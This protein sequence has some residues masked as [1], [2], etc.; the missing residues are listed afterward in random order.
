MCASFLFGGYAPFLLLSQFPA[1]R[2]SGGEARNEIVQADY[3]QG[4][5]KELDQGPAYPPGRVG[6]KAALGSR[7]KT[8][9][10]CPAKARHSEE[11]ERKGNDTLPTSQKDPRQ[12][13]YS[14]HKDPATSPQ[15]VL[16]KVGES[17]NVEQT[18][19]GPDL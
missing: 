14:Q 19:D 4:T 16:D 13:G 17:Q 18:D 9:A 15:A 3:N 8:G 7:D 2:Q 12:K 6:N 10:E 5:Q 11:N 1:L